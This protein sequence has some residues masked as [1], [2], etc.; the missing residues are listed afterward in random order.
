MLSLGPLVPIPERTDPSSTPNQPNSG[1]VHLSE[2]YR[3]RFFSVTPFWCHAD[4]TT[5]SV[6]VVYA[7][8]AGIGGD[9]PPE[10][11]I[12]AR[13]FAD[14]AAM[15]AGRPNSRKMRAMP[16]WITPAVCVPGRRQGA[17]RASP[18]RQAGLV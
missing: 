16:A 2:V 6:L 9:G 10:W 3:R 18:A 1:H 8:S 5:A 7:A 17:G 14:I 4:G 13:I 15:M 11:A 12:S